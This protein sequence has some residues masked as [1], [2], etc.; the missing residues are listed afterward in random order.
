MALGF[1][2]NLLTKLMNVIKYPQI[3]A[4]IKAMKEGFSISGLYTDF[5]E[6]SMA[7]VYFLQGNHKK[8]AVFDYFFR[9]IPFQGGFVVF[10]GLSSVLEFLENLQFSPDEIEFLRSKG[11]HPDFL[12]FL[13][14]FR[15]KGKVFAPKEGELVFPTE[16]ILRVE[17]FMLEAQIVETLIL[18]F[19]NFQSLIATKAARMRMVAKDKILIDFG[20]RRAQGLGGY[21]A[22]K[23]CM[24]GGFNGTSNVKAAYDFG[25]EPVGTM[26]HSF[27]QSYDDELTAFREF[28]MNRPQNCTLLV[29]TYDTLNSGVPNAIIVGKEMEKRGQRLTG[30]RLDSGDLAYLSKVTRRMLDEAGLDYVKITASNQLD[31]WVIKSLLEQGAAIDVFGVGTSLVTAPPDAALDG[32]YK[33]AF[34]DGKPRI[35]ISENLK[36]VTLPGKKQVF[37]AYHS[38][39]SL[40]GADIV[41]FDEE[42]SFSKMIHP[43]DPLQHL[44]LHAFQFKPVLH[45]VME[46]GKVLPGIHDFILLQNIVRN[47]WQNCRMSTKDLKTPTFIK[48]ESVKLYTKKELISNQVIKNKSFTSYSIE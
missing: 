29:D 8:E 28:A 5:Y 14:D 34:A 26:A 16:P 27:V 7:Q 12:D 43:F 35:K 19:L 39:G 13:A 32:V 10:A 11:L 9:K 18:N 1:G 38:D 33:L 21:H 24:V 22:A 44:Q 30:I 42:N 36:K 40:A 23:A 46:N 15:F 48:W 3:I 25:L 45:L 6:L 47:N 20:L 41:A 4:E 31:E 17:G 37:R 2:Y